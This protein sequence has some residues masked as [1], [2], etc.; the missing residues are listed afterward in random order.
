M[1]TNPFLVFLCTYLGNCSFI[2]L[3]MQKLLSFNGIYRMRCLFCR[4]YFE[5]RYIYYWIILFKHWIDSYILDRCTDRWNYCRWI[6]KRRQEWSERFVITLLDK[7]VS[8]RYSSKFTCNFILWFIWTLL[9]RLL[10][11]I[12]FRFINNDCLVFK[13]WKKW[14]KIK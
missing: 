14:W 7:F 4:S 10:L 13:S 2:Q 6:K 1:F 3:K 12:S 8:R 11:S 9:K 5:L